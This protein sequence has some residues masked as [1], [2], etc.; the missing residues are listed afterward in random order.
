M[1]TAQQIRKAY[2]DYVLTNNEKPK[3][4]YSFAKKNKITEAEF[5]QF[6]SSFESIEKTIWFELTFETINKI[7]EQEVWLQY[8]SREKM[9]SFFYS[10]TELLK[11]HRSFIIYTIKEQRMTLSTPQMLS[12]TFPQTFAKVCKFICRFQSVYIA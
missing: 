3:S 7:K 10:F 5:Y 2:I 8:T 6:Y 9:L 1:A 11:Q 12:Q 4:V